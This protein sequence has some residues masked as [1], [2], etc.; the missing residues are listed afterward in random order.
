MTTDG[1]MENYVGALTNDL[2]LH[3]TLNAIIVD[4]QSYK[5]VLSFMVIETRFIVRLRDALC[6]DIIDATHDVF[7]PWSV[8]HS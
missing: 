7:R 8:S 3:R 4:D 6:L 2:S 1:V 5:A